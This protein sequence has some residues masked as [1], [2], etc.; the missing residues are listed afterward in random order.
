MMKKRILAIWICSIM[1]FTACSSEAVITENESE[2][3]ESTLATSFITEPDTEP[4]S[5]S[6]IEAVTELTTEAVTEPATEP[7]TEPVTEAVTAPVNNGHMPKVLMYHAVLEKPFSVNTGLFVRPSD[8]EE[9]IQCL[10]DAGYIFLFADEYGWTREKSVILTFDDGYI[11]NYTELLPILKKYQ[12]KATVYLI[13]DLVNSQSDYLNAEQLKEMSDSGLVQFGCHTM[14]HSDMTTL[15][16]ED[17]I[18]EFEG[19]IDFVKTYTGQACTTIAY[20]Y[21]NYNDEITE[22]SKQYFKFAYTAD[23]RR[24]ND[25]TYGYH[26]PRYY[27]SRGMDGLALLEMIEG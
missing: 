26:L 15:S 22:L 4:I 21:G 27:V 7:I 14:S 2:P 25:Y 18:A 9:Q 10:Q 20:P 17:V 5:E 8:L 19:C 1:F 13:G 16:I 3:A 12:V 6:T 24:G 11:Y 23:G